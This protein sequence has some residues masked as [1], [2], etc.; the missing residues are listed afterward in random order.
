[1]KKL[2]KLTTGF[3]IASAVI[4][5][6]AAVVITQSVRR[7][8]ESG[9]IEVVSD[10]SNRDAQ[11]IASV[12]TEL[13]KNPEATSTF[14]SP[15]ESGSEMG[16]YALKTFLRS[17]NIV[18]LAL[19]GPDGE[20]L[21]SS[22][23]DSANT[24]TDSFY[25]ASQGETVTI[26]NKD[27]IFT[28][29]D[30]EMTSG[31]TTSTFLP[32]LDP[33]SQ[34]PA[35]ILEV[36]RDVTA[37]LNSRIETAQASMFTTVFGTLGGSF[38]I[39]FGIV[40]TADILIARSRKRALQQ[41]QALADKK[42]VAH[43]LELE[44][45]QLRQL[46]EERDKFLSM[47]SHELRTPLTTILGF[48]DILKRRQKGDGMERN[49]QHLELMR[50]N[51]EHLNSLIEEMLEITRIEAGRFE[52]EKEGFSLDPLIEQVKVSSAMIL[53]TRDQQLVVDSDCDGVELHADRRR[54]MQVMLNLVSNASKYSPPGSTVTIKVRLE[55]SSVVFCVEDQGP[56]IPDADQK[57][58]FDRFFRRDDEATRSQ[59]GLGL[60]L[61]IVK[62]IVHAHQG[63][64]DVWSEVGTGTMMTV[65]LP[66]GRRQ[67]E[68]A[69]D[70]SLSHPEMALEMRRLERIR[71]LRGMA[72]AARA[73]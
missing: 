72:A 6:V 40:L 62:A 44:N 47:V 60:G 55:D 65:T 51:G 48:T 57:A 64:V 13:A 63:E 35:Q 23:P 37:T 24:A 2:F 21:W 29:M 31:D 7:G 58:M 3:L 1:M 41:T 26:L 17:S 43:Q 14:G 30:G 33:T 15:S 4:F 39:L 9:L 20:A 8:E 52:V 25:R 70:A 71:D 45:Q 59:S 42:M 73:S 53:D 19:Y 32:L 50:R 46:N 10:Q 66:G 61:A 5:A 34:Q 56:G 12:V 36:A 18:R 28:G 54:V 49:Q 22:N 16:N 11:V 69:I 67:A 27:V 38:I 68:E